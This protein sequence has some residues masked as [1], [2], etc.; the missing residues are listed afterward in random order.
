[1]KE[2]K[3][4]D[5]AKRREEKREERENILLRSLRL[6]VHGVHCPATCKA[7]SSRLHL[8]CGSVYFLRIGRSRPSDYLISECQEFQR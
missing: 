3:E 7:D 5:R 6:A 1:M 8:F 2:E 4:R